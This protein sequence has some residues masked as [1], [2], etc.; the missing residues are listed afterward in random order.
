[1]S[2]FTTVQRL[3][4][5]LALLLC[6]MLTN[7]MFHGLD[8]QEADP[9]VRASLAFPQKTEVCI[10]VISSLIICPI[11]IAAVFRNVGPK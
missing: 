9:T 4:C 5:C 10:G 3:S 1:M 11:A 2:S 8:D 6:T 7:V